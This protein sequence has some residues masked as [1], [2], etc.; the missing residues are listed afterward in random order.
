VD[1]FYPQVLE[2]DFLFWLAVMFILIFSIA[3]LRNSLET[4]KSIPLPAE[5]MSSPDSP[6]SKSIQVQTRSQVRVD[7]KQ[8]HPLVYPRHRLF[9]GMGVE[10]MLNLLFM[11]ES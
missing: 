5:K 8:F 6:E 4:R 9:H 3:L 11:P 7:T 1:L 10:I 2:G